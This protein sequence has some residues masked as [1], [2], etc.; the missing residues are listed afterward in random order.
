[1]IGLI[2]K[3]DSPIIMTCSTSDGEPQN[4]GQLVHHPRH[5][6]TIK[7]HCDEVG[8]KCEIILKEACDPGSVVD[9]LL[10][11][12]GVESLKP[13]SGNLQNLG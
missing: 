10:R 13:E 1:M 12:L 8:V 5:A 4:R 6:K 2:T 7:K 3:N 9:F 11:Q